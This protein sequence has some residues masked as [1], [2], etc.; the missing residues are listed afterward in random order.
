MS[1]ADLLSAVKA[2]DLEALMQLSCER[3]PTR[4]FGEQIDGSGWNVLHHAT[5]SN[6]LDVVKFVVEH[7]DPPVFAQDY[8]GLTPLA[9]ACE[10]SAPVEIICYLLDLEK[11]LGDGEAA[12][13]CISP[14]Y[15]AVLQNRLELAEA[16]T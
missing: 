16:L 2:G 3:E 6:S 12:S 8:E 5:M 7:F 14:L 11:Q 4:A 1:D 9:L 13:E 10:R 15:Y